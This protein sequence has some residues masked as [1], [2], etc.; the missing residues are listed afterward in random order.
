[1]FFE[2]DC[3]PNRCYPSLFPDVWNRFL[4]KAYQA[5]FLLNS[6]YN[7]DLTITFCHKYLL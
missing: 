3:F 2:A 7:T 6:M 1:M 5:F 4:T